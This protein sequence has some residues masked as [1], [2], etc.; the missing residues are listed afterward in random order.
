MNV[1]FLM[2]DSLN[3]NLLS[4]YGCGWTKTPNFKRLE[5]RAVTFDQ[6]YAGSLPCM[7]SRREIHTGR[8]N[9]L[10]RSW[11]P[12]E[13]Y[14]DSMP[15]L[16]KEH[17]IH[18]HL[19]SDHQHYWE[20]GGAT[21]HTRYSS[22]ECIRG[23]EGDCWKVTPESFNPETPKANRDGI[24][25]SKTGLLQQQDHV[26]RSFIKGEA[27]YP[28][29]RTIN[30]GIDF[31]ERNRDAG[32]WFL[33]LECFDPHEPFNAAPEYR[34][35]YPEDYR[36]PQY[37]WPPYYVVTEDDSTKKH[38]RTQYAAL[39]TMV[40]HYLGKVLDTF[41]R[42]GLWEN[43]ALIVGTDH[44]Y[45]L[46]EHDWWSKTVMPVYDE[47]AHIPLF[48]YTPDCREYGGQHRQTL[49][50]TIDIPETILDLYGI[51][52]TESMQ[53]FSLLPALKEEVKLRD[54]VLFGFH[55]AHVNIFDG[56]YCY[57][58]AP[59]SQENG[60]LFEYTLVPMHMRSRFSAKELKTATLCEPFSFTKSCPVLKVRKSGMANDSSLARILN[61][62]DSP[63]AYTIDNNNLVNAANFGSK[64]FDMKKD[65]RQECEIDDICQE[66]RLG[67]LI[68]QGMLANDAPAEQFER[69]GLPMNRRVTEEDIREGRNR[70]KKLYV[71]P[72]LPE[73]SWARS[74]INA[75]KMLMRFFDPGD[76]DRV[77]R[78]IKEALSGTDHID[79]NAVVSAIP[80]LAEGRTKEMLTY[81]VRLAGRTY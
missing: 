9:F 32:P 81:F 16:L 2:F 49:V 31:L 25:F 17:G 77:S 45:L 43:T 74:G 69:I 42:Y 79:D 75:Y 14:D 13:P 37:D 20:D 54:Y 34:S 59:L 50:Q 65:P 24:F 21:Y 78:I 76:A 7:P 63:E 80:R 66:A 35:Q 46:G 48:I 22:W 18:S 4:A 67:E 62:P 3:R 70:E 26:N 40:D 28:L 41:D 71:P 1:V 61:N 57:M 39:L 52:K 8:Y 73:R 19:C 56:R 55:G 64:L 29:V 10:H 5:E 33:Q 30:E 15:E 60:P 23:Q 11:G 27:D 36:G 44:G 47:I 12:M 51:P 6:C 68:R 53:G 58:R 72:L 38:L